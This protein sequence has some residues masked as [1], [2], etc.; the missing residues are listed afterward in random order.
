MIHPQGGKPELMSDKMFPR[1]AYDQVGGL[2][3]F[4]RMLDKIRKKAAGLLPP[5]YH[6]N[7]GK[8]FDGRTVRFLEVD[9]E[10]LRERVRQGGTD[11]EILDWCYEKGRQPGDEKTLVWNGFMIKR[12]WRDEADGTTAEL[13]RYKAGS[14]LSHRK[15]LVTLFDYYEVDEGRT[16]SSFSDKVRKEPR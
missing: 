14:G 13:E 8:G 7:L 16:E 11:E 3:Y 5:E 9:Y 15:D 12:G 1:S 2:V 10:E 4:A 6:P